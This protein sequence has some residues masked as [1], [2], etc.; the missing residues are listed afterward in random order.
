MRSAPVRGWT[1][2]VGGAAG[3]RVGVAQP[4]RANCSAS[5]TKANA[6]KRRVDAVVAVI[7][8]FGS[9]FQKP[10]TYTVWAR[11]DGDI[12]SGPEVAAGTEVSVL[13]VEFAADRQKLS[14]AGDL[15]GA[16]VAPMRL[17]IA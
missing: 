14:Y 7:C 5:A 2:A 8:W 6:P 9:Q 10:Y 1:G 4:E 13:R 15:A 11:N 3:S 17:H 16:I 12:R